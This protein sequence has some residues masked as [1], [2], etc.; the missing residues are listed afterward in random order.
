[1]EYNAKFA[2]SWYPDDRDEL[3]ELL[4]IFFSN[5]SV[6]SLIKSKIKGIIVP[7]AGYIYSGQTA[8]YGF[9]A[10]SNEDFDLAIILAPS[11]RAYL[12]SISIF[13]Y[14]SVETPLGK[15]KVDTN[16]N[17]ELL[18]EDFFNDSPQSYENEHSFE[19]EIPFLQYICKKDYKILPL[20]VGEMSLERFKAS[21]DALTNLIS[22]RKTIIITSSDFTHYGTSFGY[23]PFSNNIAENIKK[24]DLDAIRYIEKNDP[25]GFLEY[26]NSTKAT[27]CGINP[28]LFMMRILNTSTGKL[29]SYT[30]SGELSQDY[31]NCV[32]YSSIAFFD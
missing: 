12:N 32:S 28:I 21:S 4:Q 8:A 7:H 11:H 17:K 24:H 14:S 18:K 13:N 6:S 31:S 5:V 2:G 15:L 19:L 25:E 22:S 16:L 23:T 9:K 20:I 3:I 10:I 29:L 26:C 30:N 1:M 27:I